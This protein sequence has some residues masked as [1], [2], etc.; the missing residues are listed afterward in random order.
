VFL[1][2]WVADGLS[3]AQLEAAFRSVG[4]A[5]RVLLTLTRRRYTRREAMA[6]RYAM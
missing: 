4:Q 3:P 2:P 6:F 5:F 1:V